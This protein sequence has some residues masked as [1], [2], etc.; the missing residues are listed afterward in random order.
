MAIGDEVDGPLVYHIDLAELPSNSARFPI[1]AQM[2]TQAA[3][4]VKRMDHRR[5]GAEI[6]CLGAQ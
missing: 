1:L 3:R 2:R 5:I 6:T 4:L